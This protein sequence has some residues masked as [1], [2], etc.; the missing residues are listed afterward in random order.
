MDIISGTPVI[1]KILSS[2]AVIIAADRIFKN[3]ALA[4]A[5]GTLVLAAWS[6]HSAS[7][8]AGITAEQILSRDYIV[9]ILMVFMLIWL[10]SQMKETRMMNDLV[11]GLR[12]R[13]EG[14]SLLAAV[15]AVIGLI[16]M[17][18]GALFSAPLV[19]DCDSG[20]TMDS[21][22][23]GKINYWFRHIWEYWLP[24]Y[25]GVLLTVQI[26]G[27]EIWQIAVL[28]FPLSVFS[29]LGGY[30][31]LLRKV[32]L[33]NSPAKKAV[34]PL[35]RNMA[36]IF[37]IVF[38]YIILTLTAPGL[39]GFSRYLPMGLSILAAMIITQFMRPLSFQKWIRIL[40][41]KS[42]FD[43]VLIIAV[44]RIYGAFIEAR[45]PG[46][47]FLMDVMRDELTATGVP[48]MVLIMLLPFI[49]GFATGLAVGFVGA[50]FPIVVSI[51]G[52]N[53]PQ[54]ELLSAV[55]TAYAFGFAGQL[56]SPVHV[57]NIVTNRFFKT[58]IIKSTM[59]LTGPC[60][61]V[62][63]GALLTSAVVRVIFQH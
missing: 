59:Q 24:L 7:E 42:I 32:S 63:S 28:N 17:P 15:P 13:L 6:G 33:E 3:L 61:F 31:F 19:E 22:L 48:A 27:L 12:E 56:L 46:G 9:L 14:K 38:F 54:A 16:P 57:C 30:V 47:A 2:L 36:P 50:S 58:D 62:I 25:A 35:Y 8:M 26:T 10:S 29:V 60:L 43:M 52:H 11:A 21:Y 45:L 37:S 44:I 34:K 5:A 20:K 18:G 23:K 51:L 41:S 55:V 1:V 53:P 49:S 40:L 4:M 39:S